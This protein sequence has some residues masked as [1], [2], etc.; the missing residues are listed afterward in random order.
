[1]NIIFASHL[2]LCHPHSLCLFVA[3]IDTGQRGPRWLPYSICHTIVFM[4]TTY[5]LWSRLTE[6]CV[7]FSI[8]C[9]VTEIDKNI[10]WRIVKCQITTFE[11]ADIVTFSTAQ[12]RKA[13]T[14]YWIYTKYEQTEVT[15]P[16]A[17][18]NSMV[19]DWLN[20]SFQSQFSD[21]KNTYSIYVMYILY[22]HH[23]CTS[24]FIG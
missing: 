15:V 13:H 6:C 2:R 12:Q 10:L 22:V 11:T 16:E 18:S 23:T 14:Q 19:I 8:T 3:S 7:D 9:S 4:T 1:M 21:K 24:T 17:H 20:K 5:I